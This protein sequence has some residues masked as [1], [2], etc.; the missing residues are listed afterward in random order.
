[1]LIITGMHRSGT[2]MFA[3][4]LENCGV[5][6]GTGLIDSD[7]GNPRGYFENKDI[8]V[9]NNSILNY[10]KLHYF[11]NNT[12][13]LNLNFSSTHR[14]NAELIRTHLTT[15]HKSII[16]I[17]DPRVCLTIDFWNDVFK[18][19]DVYYIFLY[20]DP[21]EVLAS[22]LRRGTDPDITQDPS[23][24]LKSYFLYNKNIL[25]F[26]NQNKKTILINISKFMESPEKTI[27]AIN[28]AFGM[29]LENNFASHNIIRSEF[30]NTSTIS[31]M[32]RLKLMKNPFLL[33]KCK[34]LYGKL[35]EHGSNI[36]NV[37]TP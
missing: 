36:N 13:E 8:V 17:K 2:S 16:A 5:T 4:S 3:K 15:K 32:T 1:M 10:N 20:R 37:L 7:I 21:T 19:D 35:E 12:Q 24:A 23:I 26:S 22:L 18:N 27:G 29:N 11:I 34:Y 30:N 9:L 6:L 28:T 14:N 31:F 25:N 33:K